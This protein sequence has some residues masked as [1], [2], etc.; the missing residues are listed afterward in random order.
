M[1]FVS[2]SDA[3]LPS[4]LQSSFQIIYFALCSC[5]ILGVTCLGICGINKEILKKSWPRRR[6][7][8][9]DL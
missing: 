6:L 5:C 8:R 3:D 4:K 2:V 9:G 7:R 1:L